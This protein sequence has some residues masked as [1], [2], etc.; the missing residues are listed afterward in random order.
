M[1]DGEYL[2]FRLLSLFQRSITPIF[3]GM[4]VKPLVGDSKIM[5]K[6]TIVGVISLAAV[7]GAIVLFVDVIPPKDMTVTTMVET[8]VRIGLYAKQNASIP[9]S[10]DMLPRRGGYA[11]RT[12]DGWR[13]PLTYQSTTDGIVRLTSLGEDGQPGGT[14]DDAEISIAYRAR[15]PDGSLWATSEMWIVE[16][17]IRGEDP[18]QRR[19]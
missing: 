6:K 15:R 2:R 4:T 9:E 17:E 1:F 12:V 16:A 3:H 10:L 7:I 19:P 18:Q 11:N 13:R 8:F 14:G 5:A